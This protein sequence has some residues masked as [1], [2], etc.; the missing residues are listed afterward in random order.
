MD[1]LSPDL[2]YEMKIVIEEDAKSGKVKEE[3]TYGII[4]DIAK[5]GRENVV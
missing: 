1:R 2:R 4:G 3:D 5:V